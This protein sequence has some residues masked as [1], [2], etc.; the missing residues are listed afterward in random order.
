MDWIESSARIVDSLD[1]PEFAPHLIA[2]L[3]TVVPFEHTVIFAYYEGRKPIAL[4]D[5]FPD[6]KR[7]VMVD[8][9][10]A[11][12]YLLDP[13]FRHAAIVGNPRL[14]RLRDL[15]P[16]RFYQGEYF[17][18]YYIQTGLAEEIGFMVNLGQGVSIV[19]SAMRTSRRF[20]AWEFRKLRDLLPFVNAV[21]R[22]NWANLVQRFADQPAP[23]RG[24]KLA[25]LIDRAFQNIGSNLLTPREAE[26]VGYILKGY[27]A[28]ATSQALGISLGTV[29]IHKRNLYGKLRISSQGELF[30]LFIAALTALE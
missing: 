26:I 14:V 9:Y 17:R 10:Q 6:K 11:G 13:F 22:R 27:S 7:C 3:R 8:D 5:D 21:S 28:K 2:A 16:D 1:T 30:S 15:A 20:S 29:R 18:N 23:A 12:P 25:E 19:I 4:H 24:P